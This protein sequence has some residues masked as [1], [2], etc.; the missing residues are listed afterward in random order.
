MKKWYR[1]LRFQRAPLANPTSRYL[2]LFRFTM[3]TTYRS[4][5]DTKDQQAALTRIAVEI[6]S[7]TKLWPRSWHLST[8]GPLSWATFLRFGYGYSSECL[9]QSVYH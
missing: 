5:S 7:S 4:T 3:K 2:T 1:Y 9:H 6:T 8:G